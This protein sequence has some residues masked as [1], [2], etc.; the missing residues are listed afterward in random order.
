MEIK[1]Q[2][3]QRWKLTPQRKEELYK[4][5]AAGMS[6]TE[7]V[8]KYNL[9]S[10]TITYHRKQFNK[11]HPGFSPKS[12]QK[13]PTTNQNKTP[14]TIDVLAAIPDTYNIEKNKSH[15]TLNNEI[16]RLN[17]T[18]DYLYR[19]IQEKK[20]HILKLDSL[21]KTN[22]MIDNDL[23]HSPTALLEE[24]ETD[25]P[26]L[27]E[28]INIILKVIS[29]LVDNILILQEEITQLKD[30]KNERKAG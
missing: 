2:K 19:N 13:E 3:N 7:C 25:R 18:I 6:N 20:L 5:L 14:K 21:L 11:K 29:I 15:D 30:L 26:A 17:D 22:K 10:P 12:G 1:E 16:S 9:A 4:D 24:V 27:I 8:K 23:H 28:T